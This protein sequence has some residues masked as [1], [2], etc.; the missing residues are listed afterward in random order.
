MD[1]V[2]GVDAVVSSEAG[3][4]AAADAV[5][6]PVV[7]GVPDPLVETAGRPVARTR[8]PPAYWERIC[9]LMWVPY[10]LTRPD[11]RAAPGLW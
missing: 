8:G 1:A 10:R 4:V 5:S 7:G 2:D 11:H 6:V 3:A 9:K